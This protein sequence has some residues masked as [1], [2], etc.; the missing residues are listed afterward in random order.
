MG[1]SGFEKNAKAAIKKM[2]KKA[3]RLYVQLRTAY[4]EQGD[5]EAL[6]KAR[7]LLQE[8]QNISIGD[9]ERLFGYLEGGGKVILSEPKSL[10]TESS[11]MPDLTVRRCQSL[12]IIRS[13]CESLWS[14]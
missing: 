1:A 6:E 12:T 7:A 4:Q 13:V 3:G 8:Q 5:H 9:R 10:L 14:R 2:G 11:K